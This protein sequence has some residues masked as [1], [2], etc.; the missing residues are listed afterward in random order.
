LKGVVFDGTQ[1]DAYIMDIRELRK[2]AESGEI[3]FY[4]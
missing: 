2:S 3:E 4:L 1:A